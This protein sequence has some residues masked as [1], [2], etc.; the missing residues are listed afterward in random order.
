MRE[1]HHMRTR[2]TEKQ[3]EKQNHV[4]HSPPPHPF[5]PS[6]RFHFI[7]FLILLFSENC[8]LFSLQIRTKT[9]PAATRPTPHESS[10]FFPRY[11]IWLFGAPLHLFRPKR[12]H[13]ANFAFEFR[14]R[15][16]NQYRPHYLASSRANRCC[17]TRVVPK[18]MARDHPWL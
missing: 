5:I 18:A 10:G 6:N 3:L 13:E 9:V 7:S 16:R 1:S 8:D 17:R 14:R 12:V 2:K 11:S 15:T 4:E